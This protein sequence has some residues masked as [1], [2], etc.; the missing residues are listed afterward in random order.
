MIEVVTNIRG[1]QVEGLRDLVCRAVGMVS[2]KIE[3]K[4]TCVFH[5]DVILVLLNE[6][7]KNIFSKSTVDKPA[8]FSTMKKPFMR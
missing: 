5:C 2:D 4:G 1:G 8:N 3:N 6:L 7:S